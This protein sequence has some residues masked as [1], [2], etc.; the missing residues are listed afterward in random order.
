MAMFVFGCRKPL[1]ST[2]HSLLL[3]LDVVPSPLS[4]R[5]VNS[6]TISASGGEII[7]IV[8]CLIQ[9]SYIGDDLTQ[10]LHFL[11]L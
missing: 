8:R 11:D 6:A 10:Q 4:I 7:V 1:V 2:G 5:A 3:T 9:D